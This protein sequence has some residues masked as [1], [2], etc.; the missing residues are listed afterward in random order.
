MVGGVVN[1][2]LTT[3]IFIIMEEALK[4]LIRKVVLPKYY[5]I[6]DFDVHVR[7]KDD[8]GDSYRV[9]YFVDKDVHYERSV[10]DNIQNDTKELYDVLGLH[11]F[12]FYEG[13]MFLS[14]QS[15]KMQ[16]SLEKLIGEV[17]L[18]KYPWIKDFDVFGEDDFGEYIYS[19]HYYVDFDEY[20]KKDRN[21]ETIQRDQ[22]SGARDIGWSSRRFAAVLWLLVSVTKRSI[23]SFMMGTPIKSG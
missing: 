5:W 14:Y 9:L 2:Y 7:K 17:I 8:I 20:E 16:Q 12:D 1:Y 19:I 15:H 4:K 11:K 6:K 22:M 3:Y 13:V 10:I 21:E 18:P 23:M